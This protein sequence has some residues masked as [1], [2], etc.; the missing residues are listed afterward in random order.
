MSEIHH[1]LVPTDGSKEA[2]A[3]AAHAG[4]LARALGARISMLMVQD[5]ELVIQQ[6][7]GSGDYAFGTPH[8]AMETDE[9]RARLE[10][11]AE[12]HELADTAKA[13]GE[14]DSAPTLFVRWGHAA[15]KICQFA[16][17]NAVDLIVM[18]SHGRTGF[19]RAFLGSISQAVA[20]HAPCPVTIVR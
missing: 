10:Q 1:I 18:G 14:L 15:E 17:D 9:I 5:E 6:A 16:T 8:A 13:V 7:L 2:R 4:V 19:Q 20:N 12:Q 3:A 11:R